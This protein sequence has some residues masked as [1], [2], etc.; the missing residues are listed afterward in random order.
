ML[1]PLLCEL[2]DVDELDAV[3]VAG[4]PPAGVGV[5][6]AGCAASVC[7]VAVGWLGSCVAV[8][9]LVELLDEL[10]VLVDVLADAVGVVVGLV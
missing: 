10:A 1:L 2:D 5:V 3:V 9:L 8:E 4:G 7:A 6:L